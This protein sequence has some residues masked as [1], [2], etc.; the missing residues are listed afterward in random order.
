[1]AFR[2]NFLVKVSVEVLW[3]AI[4]VAFFRTV[5][6]RTNN[7]AGWTE[8]QYFFFVGCFFAINGVIE[9]FFLD[10]CNEFAELVRT[11]DLDGL[12]LKPIDEQFLITCRRIDWGTAP[13]VLMGS[14]VMG[15]SLYQMGWQFD[16]LRVASFLVS[17]VV[18]HG[19]RLQ[20]HAALDVGLG[21]DGAEPELDGDVV[22]VFERGAIPARDLRGPLGRSG[23]VLHVLHADSGRGERAGQCDG[24]RARPS[25]GGG[26]S[27][28]VMHLAL[29]Y[30][31]V[32]SVCAAVVSQRE[33]LKP[34]WLLPTAILPSRGPARGT[35]SERSCRVLRLDGKIDHDAMDRGIALDH[36]HSIRALA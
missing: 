13:N 23:Q 8:Q 22:A 20:L 18:R 10:N 32:L 5:F 7:I 30:A 4:M 27:R 9:M 31:A 28:R 24:A 1:M 33:Q 16:F 29:A 15:I 19:D 11:G 2:G 17:V 26:H 34:D 6:A 21:L 35:F 36:F 14:A 12:L 3:L 25:G